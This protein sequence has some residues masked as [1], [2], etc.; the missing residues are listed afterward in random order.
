M[1]QG[2]SSEPMCLDNKW[3]FTLIYA[4]RFIY[5][6]GKCGWK[7]QY[8]NIAIYNTLFV[9]VRILW[10]QFSCKVCKSLLFPTLYNWDSE[11]FTVNLGVTNGEVLKLAAEVDRLQKE[12]DGAKHLL[13]VGKLYMLLISFIFSNW[14]QSIV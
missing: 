4:A 10:I 5:L 7:L 6:M 11:L 14:F 1:K 13:K 8:R 9:W 3:L 12:A 2:T